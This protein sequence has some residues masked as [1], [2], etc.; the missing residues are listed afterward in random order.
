MVPYFHFSLCNLRV[1]CVSVVNNCSKNSPQRH[2]EHGGCT[3]NFK[4]GYYRRTGMF[5]LLIAQRFN[6]VLAG[7]AQG[8]IE[9]ADAAADN[10]HQ[11]RN[12]DPT[13]LN[14]HYQRGHAHY[15]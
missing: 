10:P 5:V 11:K 14:L 2:R 9:G 12:R 8:R 3:E 4:L 6:R 13:R 15:A 1:L 7:G